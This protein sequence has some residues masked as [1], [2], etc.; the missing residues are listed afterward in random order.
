MSPNCRKIRSELR[1]AGVFCRKI[2]SELRLAGVL[3][4]K[5]RDFG[6]PHTGAAVGGGIFMV[7]PKLPQNTW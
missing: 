2:R 5:I 6:A 4:R 3:C 1:L 7:V